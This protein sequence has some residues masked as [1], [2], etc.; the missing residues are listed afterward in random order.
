M[1]SDGGDGVQGG[2]E[3]QSTG[4]VLDLLLS[5]LLIAALPAGSASRG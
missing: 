3:M 5:T 1:C 2:E 4:T